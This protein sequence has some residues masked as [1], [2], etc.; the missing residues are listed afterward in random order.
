[1]VDHF[2]LVQLANQAVAKFRGRV[3]WELKDRR[4]GKVDP[5]WANRKRLLT[6][7]E[8]LSD[9][10]FRRMWNAIVDE[11][12]SHQIL[13]AYIGKEEFRRLLST[14]RVGGDPHLARHRLHR[15]F[16]WCADSNVPELLTLAATVDTWWP[17]INEFHETGITNA[18]TE[19][20]NRLVRAVKRSAC[21]FLEPRELTAA[22]T[23]PLHPSTAG[24]RTTVFML[25][26]HTKSKS[27]H[28]GAST[29]NCRSSCAVAFVHAHK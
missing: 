13:M 2:H 15:F 28:G 22:D 21:G 12:P 18:R 25:T 23:I 20:Y 16:A 11:D 1:M 6:A 8:W 5:E 29:G 4:G 26:A 10:N 24:C 7:R 14:V 9:K 3:T 19:G 27:P 17:E